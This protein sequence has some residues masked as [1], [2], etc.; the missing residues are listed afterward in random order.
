MRRTFPNAQFIVTTHSPQ[1]LTTVK[2]EKIFILNEGAVTKPFDTPYAKRSI[3]ALEDLMD[4]NS[5]PPLDEVDLLDNY[6]DKIHQG[7]IDSEEVLILRE[8]LNKL[9]GKNY[10]QLEIADMIINKWKSL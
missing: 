10:Q 9:Y 2:K 8:Q 7:D 5:R 4:T 1:I 3:V 6:L